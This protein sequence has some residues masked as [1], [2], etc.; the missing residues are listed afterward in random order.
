MSQPAV[1]TRVAA[2]RTLLG[3]PVNQLPLAALVARAVRAIDEPAEAPFTF[4]CANPHSLVVARRDAYFRQCLRSASAVVAD[5]IGVKVAG[6]IAGSQFGPR[7]TGWDFFH[8]TMSALDHRGGKAFFFGSRPEVLERLACRVEADYP[9]VRIETYSPPYGEWTE[10]ENEAML[11]RIRAVAPDVLWVGMTAPR[12]EK[13]MHANALLTKAPVIGAIGAVFDYYAGTV[14]RA[15]AWICEAGL[16][17]LYRLAGE[18]RRLWKRTVVSAPQFLW[19]V[20]RERFLPQA[21]VDADTT[22]AAQ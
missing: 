4:A 21:D 8:A 16:E 7:I 5:G 9:G 12:Q 19:L 20:A 10:A 1:A 2:E 13:W 11:K 22:V 3:I 14:K 18:P 17:W 6:L 15:P